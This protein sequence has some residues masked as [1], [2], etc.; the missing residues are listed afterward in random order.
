MTMSAKNEQ[1]GLGKAGLLLYPLPLL[2]FV[3]IWHLLTDTSPERQFIF[4]SPALVW[5]AFTKLVISGDLLKHTW[6]TISEAVLGFILGTTS[7]AFI[8]LF[9][10]YF[11][12]LAKVAR[13]YVTALGTIPI[14]ALAPMIIVW[15][16]IGMWSKVMLA[17][18]STVAVAI[19]QSYQGAT[20]IEPR[21]MRFMHVAGASRWQIFKLVV[22]PSSLIWVINA[23]RL[24]IGLAL[25]G[26]FIGEFIS[27][28]EGL[29]YMIV[30]ASGLYDMATVIVGIIALIVIALVLTAA[31]DLLERR[32]LRWR[33]R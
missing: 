4:A 9:F 29:G 7:G 16:G 21:F 2:L 12:T 24:N 17:F 1:T 31:I 14:F 18:L 20:S 11:K 28:E 25:L 19:V 33:Y 15:F 13:P 3:L 10:W 5:A 22:V 6:V 26:A 8:G 27:A 32:L 23:M 30:K